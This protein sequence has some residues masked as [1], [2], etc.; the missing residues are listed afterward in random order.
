MSSVVVTANSKERSVRKISSDILKD[1]SVSA[2]VT[3]GREKE[4]SMGAFTKNETGVVTSSEVTFNVL[5]PEVV[6]T[7]S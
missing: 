6:H 2:I 7:T 1:V 3:T 5:I 4:A